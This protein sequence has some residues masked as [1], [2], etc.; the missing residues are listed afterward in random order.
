MRIYKVLSFKLHRLNGIILEL[1]KEAKCIGVIL[2][3]KISWN[4]NPK[5]RMEKLSI[6]FTCARK[7]L[8]KY[9]MRNRISYIGC[10][11]LSL[12]LSLHMRLLYGG[13]W[14]RHK[15]TYFQLEQ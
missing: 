5:S 13:R 7:L 4:R 6:S 10:T 2:Y 3:S 11:P 1:S 14:N 12:D 8:Q 9:E 15:I